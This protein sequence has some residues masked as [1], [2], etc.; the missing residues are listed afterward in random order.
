MAL[1]PSKKKKII[2][3]I[4]ILSSRTENFLEAEPPN[5]TSE[6]ESFLDIVIG[7]KET[8]YNLPEDPTQGSKPEQDM[9][10]EVENVAD[11]LESGNPTESEIEGMATNFEAALANL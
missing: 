3:I 10:A 11:A 1:A 6:S 7:G 8:L 5:E 9:W 2:R 4:I